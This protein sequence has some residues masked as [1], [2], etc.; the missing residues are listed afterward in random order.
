MP[1]ELRVSTAV[2]SA[3]VLLRSIAKGT[4]SSLA[5]SKPSV[6]LGRTQLSA[7][8]NVASAEKSLILRQFLISSP[9]VPAASTLSVSCKWCCRFR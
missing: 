1:S 3:S 5:V 4:T 7:E 9:V 6:F 8:V 2:R